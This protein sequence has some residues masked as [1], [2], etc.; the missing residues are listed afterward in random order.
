MSKRAVMRRLAVVGIIAGLALTIWASVAGASI[1]VPWDNKGTT[2]GACSTFDSDLLSPGAGQQGWL[3]VLNQVSPDPSGNNGA[4]WSI[5]ATFNPGGAVSGTVVQ[6]TSSVVK[7]A[8]YSSDNAL[9]VSATVTAIGVAL[10]C[11]AGY[12]LSRFRFAGRELSLRSFLFSQM[13]PGVVTTYVNLGRAY[14]EESNRAEA[15]N[16]FRTS[17][18]RNKAYP[19][20]YLLLAETLAAEDRIP[21]AITQL[22]AGVRDAGTDPELLLALGRAYQKVG[23]FADARVKLEEAVKADPSGPVGK[24][25][26]ELL[27]TLGR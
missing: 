7:F 22:E 19:A 9:L 26:G 5:T 14:V 18:T 24:T 3:F 15:M 4:D 25:A 6:T 12:A 16:W 8:V 21:E 23:R 10:A 27:K 11:T 1:S 13:F 20:P 2:D 17:L